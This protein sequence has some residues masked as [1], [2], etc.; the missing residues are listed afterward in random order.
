MERPYYTSE[1]AFSCL[2][3]LLEKSIL[4]FYQK[5]GSGRYTMIYGMSPLPKISG[6]LIWISKCYNSRGWSFLKL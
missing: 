5:K 2:Q 6:M 1:M 4:L 3:K